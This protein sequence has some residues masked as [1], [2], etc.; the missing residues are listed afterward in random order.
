MRSVPWT[1]LTM[2]SGDLRHCIPTKDSPAD[3]LSRCP[4]TASSR[5]RFSTSMPSPSRTQLAIAHQVAEATPIGDFEATVLPP[6]RPREVA[7][8]ANIDGRNVSRKC[9]V[10]PFRQIILQVALQLHR[11]PAA[12]VAPGLVQ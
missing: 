10:S 6:F 12:G 3:F 5:L 1:I 8:V 9:L 4:G 2:S 7:A 11:L